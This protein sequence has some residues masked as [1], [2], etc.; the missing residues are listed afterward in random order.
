ML[1]IQ[2]LRSPE[3]DE[4]EKNEKMWKTAFGED[5]S[6]GKKLADED[7]NEVSETSTGIGYY[8][9]KMAIKPFQKVNGGSTKILIS[10]T[11]ILQPGF[12]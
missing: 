5:R 2:V 8:A 7:D 4:E 12:N 9:D 1:K 11:T 3:L 10:K 6:A